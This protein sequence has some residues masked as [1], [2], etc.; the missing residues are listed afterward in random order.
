MAGPGRKSGALL[1]CLLALRDSAGNL[2]GGECRHR[3]GKSLEPG[4]EP[5]M[6]RPPGSGKAQV[7]ITERACRRDLSDMRR[8]IEAGRIAFQRSERARDLAG[9]QVEPLLL[10]L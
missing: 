8:G 4:D 10:M 9:L 7:A 6:L 2:G 5:R 3:C 1:F